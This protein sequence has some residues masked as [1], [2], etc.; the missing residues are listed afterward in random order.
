MK[1]GAQ[2][3][4]KPVTTATKSTKFFH[5]RTC[6]CY[7]I[8]IVYHIKI[9]NSTEDFRNPGSRL[10]ERAVYRLPESESYERVHGEHQDH[11]HE[12]EDEGLPQPRLQIHGQGADRL[13]AEIWIF[14]DRVVGAYEKGGHEPDQP[15]EEYDF[16]NSRQA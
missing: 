4:K 8:V 15:N 5:D 1:S 9:Q 11:G 2:H 14:L 13:V 10:V 6:I 12:E 3:T 16:E 7:V